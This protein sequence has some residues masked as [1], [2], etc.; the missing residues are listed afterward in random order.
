LTGTAE[1][2]SANGASRL[3][4]DKQGMARVRGGIVMRTPLDEFRSSKECPAL[5]RGEEA[6][7]LTIERVQRAMETGGY[8]PDAPP[9]RVLPV[10]AFDTSPTHRNVKVRAWGI[11]DNQ[12]CGF[13]HAEVVELL[14]RR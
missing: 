2:I 12:D 14:D 13:L 10:G 1:R 3:R 11:I 4:F 5:E 9:T 6:A 8:A 7:V